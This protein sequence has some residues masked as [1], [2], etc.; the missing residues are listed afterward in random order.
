MTEPFDGALVYALCEAAGLDPAAVI[1]I[2]IDHAD[3]LFVH[4]VF[5]E[6]GRVVH[7]AVPSPGYGRKVRKG[8]L[9]RRIVWPGRTP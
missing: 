4:R 9:R 3:I 8:E 5:D 7:D 2:V 6:D 1:G